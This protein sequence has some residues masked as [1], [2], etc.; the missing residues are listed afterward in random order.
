M[1]ASYLVGLSLVL[2]AGSVASADVYL[3]G[4]VGYGANA[5]GSS[6]TEPG[7][8]DNILGTSNLG[9]TINGA[10]RGTTFLLVDG[11][12]DFTYTGM[13]SGYNALSL[14][15]ESTAASLVRPFGSAPDLVVYGSDTPLTPVAG[16]LV[17]TNGVFSGTVAYP[18]NSSFTMG[19]RVIT[20][21]QFTGGSGSGILRLNVTVVPA[22]AGL[23]ALAGAGLIATR[24]RRR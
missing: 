16:A 4:V 22:P 11:N 13:W 12:N 19:D 20:A 2:A 14:Y 8:F 10:A 17:Q 18:G 5:S 6:T 23:G 9:V 24:R 21:T 15:F 1:R 7:E 3:S